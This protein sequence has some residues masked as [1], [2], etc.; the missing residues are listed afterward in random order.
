MSYSDM[1]ILLWIIFGIGLLWTIVGIFTDDYDQ[2]WNYDTNWRKSLLSLLNVEL[3]ND[4]YHYMA[5][6]RLIGKSK[7]S[8]TSRALDNFGVTSLTDIYLCPKFQTK[9]IKRNNIIS[10]LG[11]N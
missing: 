6:G 1:N 3:E 11:I 2:N 10:K 5:L 4:T 8:L 7:K 9:N